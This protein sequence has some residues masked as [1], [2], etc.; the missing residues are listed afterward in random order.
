MLESERPNLV[1]VAPRWVGERLAMVTAAAAVGAHVYVEKP[2]A[3]SLAAADRMLAAAERAGVKMAVAHQSRLHPAILHA[4][5]LVHQGAVGRLRLV[6]G[7][8]K[9]DHRG[10]A[11]DLMILGCHVLHQ[12]RFFA[13]DATWVSGELLVGSRLAG[14]DDVRDGVEEI[15]PVAG[16][17][18]RATFGFAGGVI[19][20]FESFSG[21]GQTEGPY[22]IDLIGDEGQ[23]SLRGGFT[24]SLL[25]YLRPHV[26]PG[27]ADD[28]WQAVEVPNASPGDVPGPEEIPAPE[29]TRR[30]NQRPLRD[31]L[32]AIE[33]GRE[34]ATSGE[35]ARATL[36]MIQGIAAAH[37]N[38]GRVE[39]P[40]L[41]RE[42]PL[43]ETSRVT[44]E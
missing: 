6:R 36:E 3:A 33:E 28:Q 39:L 19:G 15:G 22:G 37:V 29:L 30:G 13:G 20:F 43:R 4:A 11:Q 8:G 24:K 44:S 35:S 21:L 32:N 1:V 10:G 42:H 31:L 40:L 34:P 41:Q 26:T 7:Y 2:L 27:V 12:M 18:V 17:G 23:L 9:M 5:A 38:G 25:R 16:D 14:F